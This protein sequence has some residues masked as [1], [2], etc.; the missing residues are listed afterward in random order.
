MPESCA[1]CRVE[2]AHPRDPYC[3]SLCAR[4]DNGVPLPD[5]T[6]LTKTQKARL[7]GRPLAEPCDWPRCEEPTCGRRFEPAV[8][9]KT[10]EPKRWC[11]M[12]ETVA[13]VA[14]SVMP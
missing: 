11:S 12:V 10:G 1:F 3:S 8:S 13:A 5:D 14:V 7:A 4:L 2:P 9:K 6:R